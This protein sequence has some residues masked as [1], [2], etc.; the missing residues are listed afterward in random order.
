MHLKLSCN[1]IVQHGTKMNKERA[2]PILAKAFRGGLISTNKNYK[3]VNVL[4]ERPKQKEHNL[5]E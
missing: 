5:F 1:K 2:K 3:P 4:L